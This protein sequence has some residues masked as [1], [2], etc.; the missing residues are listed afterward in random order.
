MG[1][2][3]LVGCSTY[4]YRYGDLYGH[5]Y[6]ML[7]YSYSFLKPEVAKEP[8]FHRNS[9]KT[10]QIFAAEG[11]LLKKKSFFKKC[12][13]KKKRIEAVFFDECFIMNTNRKN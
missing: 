7:R 8:A 10:R 2:A 4:G 6:Q 12:V 5:F 9:A 11:K 13:L 1:D 3:A